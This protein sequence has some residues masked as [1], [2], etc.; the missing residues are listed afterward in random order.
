MEKQK[1]R[2]KWDHAVKPI[3]PQGVQTPKSVATMM[4]SMMMTIA[5][6]NIIIFN[7]YVAL[8]FS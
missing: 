5:L 4:I 8:S 1:V 3:R 6:F 7:I 2:Q